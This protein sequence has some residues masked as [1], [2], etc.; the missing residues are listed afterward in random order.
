MRGIG[1]P[2][3]Y[4]RAMRAISFRRARYERIAEPWVVRIELDDVVETGY[5]L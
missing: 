3:W 2:S 1:V 5:R 4:C